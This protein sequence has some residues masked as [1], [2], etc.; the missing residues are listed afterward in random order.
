MNYEC[1]ICKNEPNSHSFEL[2]DYNDQTYF[3]Y[4]CPAKAIKS[5]SYT[6]LRAHETQ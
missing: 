2:I 1:S 4:T 3:F 5:V 6:H